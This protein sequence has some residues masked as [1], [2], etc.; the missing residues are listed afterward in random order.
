M[1]PDDLSAVL[2]RVDTDFDR[3]LQ[4]LFALLRIKS[5]SAD[6]AFNAAKDTAVV[7]AFPTTS[8]QSQ[9]TAALVHHLRSDVIPG[10]LD[11]TRARAYVGGQTAVFE[12]IASILEGRQLVFL[13]V[14][15]GI[16]FVLI[17]MAFR[18]IVVAAKAALTTAL[19]ALAADAGLVA[20]ARADLKVSSGSQ[21]EGKSPSVW[22]VM[23]AREADLGLLTEDPRWK[24]PRARPDDPVW[25]DD[26]T[27]LLRHYLRTGRASGP[28]PRPSLG[29]EGG[30]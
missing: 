1:T 11:G 18:S 22:L 9:E 19:S 30:G 23:A 12:D 27:D 7:T 20:R 25:T 8:P 3:S 14:V 2:D 24:A 29:A 5:I 26:F 6:P 28:D 16:I 21:R 17:T 13:A 10:A 4:R 15:I